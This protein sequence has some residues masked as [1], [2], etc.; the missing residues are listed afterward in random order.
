V[1]EVLR[2]PRI[3]DFFAAVVRDNREQIR[4][5][6]QLGLNDDDS[7]ENEK[8]LPSRTQRSAAREYDEQHRT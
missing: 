7:A 1:L 6:V 3:D 8:L 4:K 5:A 2:D